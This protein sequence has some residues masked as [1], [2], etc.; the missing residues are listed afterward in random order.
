MGI[1]RINPISEMACFT[2]RLLIKWVM[3]DRDCWLE[4]FEETRLIEP[5]L[6][7]NTIL[8]WSISS[9][10]RAGFQQGCK[11][12]ITTTITRAQQ[13]RKEAYGWWWTDAALGV[14]LPRFLSS[15]FFSFSPFS[16]SSWETSFIII[17]SVFVAFVISRKK[18]SELIPLWCKPYHDGKIY[19]GPTWIVC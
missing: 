16:Q 19:A 5:A 14:Y 10:H 15:F 17:L 7:L 13:E 9:I 8:L 4:P 18:W 11:P 3:V 2:S 1:K 6:S 12:D